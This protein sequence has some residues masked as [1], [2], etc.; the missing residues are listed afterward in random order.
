MKAQSSLLTF[1]KPMANGS[2]PAAL[3]KSHDSLT[4]EQYPQRASECSPS[5]PSLSKPESTS[6]SLSPEAKLEILTTLPIPPRPL[7]PGT[8]VSSIRPEH[9]YPLKR[10]TASTLPVRYPQK[11]FNETLTDPQ[12]ADLSKVILCDERP[13][14]WI[15]CRL[16]TNPYPTTANTTSQVYIQALCILAPYRE[17]GFAT[18]LLNSVL[19]A[20]T[21]T[22]QQVS[23]VYAHV[24]ENNEDALIWYEKRSFKKTLL[25]DQYYRRLEPSGAWIVRKDLS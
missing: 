20:E 24:W 8:Q 25:V 11:F 6:S 3:E 7:N 4:P 12:I 14:G 2:L 1:F 21:V 16:E 23:F 18:H 15:R 17:S 19:Q 10:L 22:R 5:T 13:V 9:I